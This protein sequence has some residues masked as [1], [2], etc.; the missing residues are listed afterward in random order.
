LLKLHDN[1]ITACECKKVNTF[2]VF[3]ITGEKSKISGAQWVNK[4]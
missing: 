2:T 4:T 3:A 1:L